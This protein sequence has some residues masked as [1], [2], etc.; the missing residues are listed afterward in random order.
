M[1]PEKNLV[2]RNGWWSF[3]MVIGDREKWVALGTQ[4]KSA[5]LE[6]AALLRSTA[7]NERMRARLGLPPVAGDSLLEKL[8][9]LRQ[10]TSMAT[11]G[12]IIAAYEADVP[13]REIKT[14]SAGSAVSS[15]RLILRTVLGEKVDVDGLKASVLTPELFHDYE[16]AKIAA[17]KLEGPDRLQSALTTSAST[18]TQARAVFC[19]DALACAH[20]RQLKLPD[21]TRVMTFKKKGTTRKIRI[22][23]DD[24]TLERLRC[25]SD[26]LWFTAPARWLAF[27]LCCG[28]GL[29]RGEAFRARWD[30]ARQ[31]RGNWVMYLVTSADGAPKGN[32]HKKEISN[33]LWADM[34]AVRKDGDFIVPGATPDEREGVFDANVQWLRSLGFDMDKPNHELRAIYLQALDR[35][36]GRA[37]AQLGA[38]HGDA[39][40]TEI[41]TGRGTAPAVRPF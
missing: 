21:L 1:H 18:I 39:R 22:E 2:E 37:A 31:I 15:L 6:A 32:E 40:T 16:A 8:G 24:T 9:L 27:A 4:D 12:E 3:R 29:R 41:Y 17:G 10:R 25:A 34:C 7:Q 20:M 28:I 30:W 19:A 26:E 13:G 36:H 14:R 35:K 33:S 5:A 23:V 38:G 11:I